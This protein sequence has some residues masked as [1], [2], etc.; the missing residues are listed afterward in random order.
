MK[1]CKVIIFPAILGIALISGLLI[2]TNEN[3]HL[4]V[5]NEFNTA[6]NGWFG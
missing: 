2:G 1:K 6:E 4:G 5:A 3:G